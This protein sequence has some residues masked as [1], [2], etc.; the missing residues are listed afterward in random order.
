LFQH[1]REKEQ[2]RIHEEN[3]GIAKRLGRVRPMYDIIG[4][5]STMKNTPCFA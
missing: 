1:Y 4:W 5:V 2:E 3:L